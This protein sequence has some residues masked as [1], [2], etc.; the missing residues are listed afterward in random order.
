MQDSTNMPS[1]SRGEATPTHRGADLKE[2]IVY[3]NSADGS[4]Y[5]GQ[6]LAGKR[7]GNGKYTFKNK[8]FYDGEWFENRMEG[9]GLLYFPS[10][11]LA[12]E[13]EWK[14]NKFNG[15]GVLY[16]ENPNLQ[17]K[18]N[19]RKICSV[20]SDAWVR[21]EGAFLNDARNGFGILY[22]V[23]GSQFKGQFQNDTA[24]GRGRFV[25]PEG[26]SVEGMWDGNKLV[27]LLHWTENFDSRCSDLEA[28]E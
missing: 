14:M 11:R 12:Y 6:I 20:K 21:Y 18:A 16:S 4:R 7:H 15:N 3:E 23:D 19:Y 17:K 22:Y 25:T 27:E 28:F 1:T 9:Y 24:C 26:D 13:G 8:G 2:R 5:E 10:G